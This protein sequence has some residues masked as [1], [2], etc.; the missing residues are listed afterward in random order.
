MITS[1]NLLL[2]PVLPDHVYLQRGPQHELVVS[3]LILQCIKAL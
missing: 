2:T 3:E 1:V